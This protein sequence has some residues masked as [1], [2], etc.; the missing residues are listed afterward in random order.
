M[1]SRIAYEDGREGRPEYVRTESPEDEWM[2]ATDS[3][4][5][6]NSVILYKYITNPSFMQTIHSR[7][8]YRDMCR[9]YLQLI[10]IHWFRTVKEML[11]FEGD[12]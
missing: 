10:S 11:K 7:I 1:Y 8:E 6:N 5:Q 9:I 12:H 4:D 3:R 2:N